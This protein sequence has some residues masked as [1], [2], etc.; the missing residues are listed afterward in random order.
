MSEMGLY[1]VSSSAQP[2]ASAHS[3]V[4][5]CYLWGQCC[6][7]KPSDDWKLPKLVS[8]LLLVPTVQPL[9]AE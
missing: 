6:L 7:R 8:L 9:P 2:E 1:L 3:A 4:L 5:Q